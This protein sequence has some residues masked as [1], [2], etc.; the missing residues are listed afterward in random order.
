MR[1]TI[2]R[3]LRIYKALL[4]QSDLPI[5]TAAERIQVVEC[6]ESWSRL[7][8]GKVGTGN[9]TIKLFGEQDKPID[10]SIFTEE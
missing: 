4:A 6:M 9:V 10:N 8:G 7:A 1:K 2:E 3:M 5:G